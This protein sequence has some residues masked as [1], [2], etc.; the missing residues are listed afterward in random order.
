MNKTIVAIACADSP[1]PKLENLEVLYQKIMSYS[2]PT[3]TIVKKKVEYR[4]LENES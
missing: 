2:L 1:T 3:G 4:N